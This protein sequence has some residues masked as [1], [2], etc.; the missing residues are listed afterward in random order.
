M[1]AVPSSPVGTGS[2]LDMPP[3]RPPKFR[4]SFWWY[5]KWFFYSIALVVFCVVVAVASVGYGLYKELEKVVP[6]TR[7]IQT[8]TK[9]ETT[10]IYAADGKMLLAEIKGEDRIWKPFEELVK[11][12][13]KW[14]SLPTPEAKAANVR[15]V[16]KATLSIEDARFY[17]HPGMDAKRLAGA[18]V[19]NYKSGST[20]QGGSTI[21]E[22]LVVNLYQERNKSMSR[23]L[24]AA[25]LA[26]QIEKRY[27][28]D[29]ILELYVN[30]IYYGNGAYGCEAAS[31]IYFGKSSD[32]LSIGEAALLAGLP[33]RPTYFDP[34]DHFDRVKKRQKVVLNEMVEKGFIN[35]GQYYAALNDKSV[36]RTVERQE[37]KRR[38]EKRNPDRWKYPYFVAYV[39]SYLA[40]QYEIDEQVLKRGGLKIVTTIQPKL[41]EAAEEALHRQLNR[42]SPSGKL[43]GA[44]VSIDPWTGHVIALVG[45]RDYYNKARNGE[46][47][48]AVQAKRQPGSTFKPYIYA[49]AMEAGYSPRSAV[50]DSTMRTNGTEEVRRGGKEVRN[51]TRGHSGKI[52][53]LEAIGQSNNV[54][55]TRVMLKVGTN[56]VIQKAHLMGIGSNL[57]PYASLALGASDITLLEH[58]SAYGVFAT[59]GLR[60]EPTPIERVESA[61]GELLV[62]HAHPVRG[63]RVMSQEAGDKMWQMLRYVVTS[64]TGR[65]ASIRGIDVIGKTGT[66]SSNKDVWFM[67]ATPKLVAGVWIGFDKP[68]PLAHSAAGGRWCA[69]V[70]RSY[71]V[72]AMDFWN[73]RHKIEK[74]VE[75]ARLTEQSKKSAQENMKVV[76]VRLCDETGLV[77]T[78]ACPSTRTV[79]FSVASG[80][81][82]ET[83]YVHVPRATE[84]RVLGTDY[85]PRAERGDFSFDGSEERPG[86]RAPAD[87][88]EWLDQPAADAGERSGERPTERSNERS[89]EREGSGRAPRSPVPRAEERSDVIIH[90]DGS[91]SRGQGDEDVVIVRPGESA[92]ASRSTSGGDEGGY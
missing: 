46:F 74:M 26:L 54:A 11:D 84:T 78:N 71:M 18:A 77:A 65:N 67:G 43:E 62:D 22:Q 51:Y 55:A 66:T 48:R 41:Q 29:E 90:S 5:L 33:Q 24:Q 17:Q 92:P 88:G 12:P 2:Q 58:T 7:L 25:L 91:T 49:A 6:D 13:E 60:A 20:T 85:T 42:L 53:F 52:S 16:L 14:P 45:G 10:R 31:Q 23:R 89:N 80:V 59:R 76:R 64:G 8:R 36:Q 28:K 35:R 4:H 21:T 81:P 1:A 19:A 3:A 72:Q 82:E 47:N 50:V 79:A 57:V 61:T 86:R 56:A 69:P 9:A 83:C 15:N 73:R 68:K 40:K 38:R 44:L 30:E 75:D 27:S 63:A 70:W 34:F 32:S 39:K 37:L 87:D